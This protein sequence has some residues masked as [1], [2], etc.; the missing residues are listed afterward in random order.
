LTAYRDPAALYHDGLFR[1]FYTYIRHEQGRPYWQIA[2]SVSHDL[3]HWTA[4]KSITPKDPKLNFASPGNV[5]RFG[6]HWI[7]CAQTYPTPNNEKYGND[8]ARIWI[9]RSPD[10]KNW[11]EPELLKVKGPNVPFEEMGRLIDPYLVE[12]KD[13]PGRWWCFFDDNAA[14]VS[15]SYDLVGWTYVGRFSA[16]ENVCVLARDDHYLMFHSPKNGIGMKRSKDLRNWQDTGRLITLGQQHWS[17]AQGRITAGFVLDLRSKPEVG[18]YL[19]FCHG[20]G[21][22]GEDVVFSTHACLGL[23]WSDDLQTWDWPGK[24]R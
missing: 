17:W 8:D 12:D 6:D 19:M 2:Y 11:H 14:N 23:A 4:P 15:Y 21:P 5:I 10:L 1:L 3:I 24:R 18:K 16:G 13:E 20:T 7:L 9:M 22:Q